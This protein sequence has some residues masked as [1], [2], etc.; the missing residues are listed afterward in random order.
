MS[1]SI[2]HLFK[3]SSINIKSVAPNCELSLQTGHVIK[4]L[5]TR[6][7]STWSR[8]NVAKIFTFSNF[9]CC[10]LFW[11]GVFYITIYLDRPHKTTLD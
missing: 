2:S 1:S 3:K 4:L 8:T 5:S 10:C 7:T 11:M 6:L 9:N